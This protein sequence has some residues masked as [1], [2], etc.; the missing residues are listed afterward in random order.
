MDIYWIKDKKQC[1][2]ATVPDVISRLQIGELTEDSLGWHAGCQSW[3]PLR[4]LPALADFLHK[5][6]DSGT[7][8]E[9]TVPVTDAPPAETPNAPATSPTATATETAPLPAETAVPAP[10]MPALAPEIPGM[11]E[12]ASQRVYLPSPVARLLARFVDGGL[13][14]VLY[15]GVIAMRDLPYDA[16]LILMANPLLWLP[17]LFLEA[18]MLSTWGTTPGKALMGIR[19]TTF[20]EVPRLSYLRALM[21]AVMVFTLG[22]GLMVPQL[23]LIMLGFEYW[24]LRRRGITPWDARCSTLPTQKEPASPSRHTLAVISLYISCVLYF[25]CMRPWMPGMIDDIGKTNPELAQSL[26]ALMPPEDKKAAAPS[27][28]TP[29]T[30][31]GSPAAAGSATPAPATTSPQD[32]SLPGI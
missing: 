15:G 22:L 10:S 28:E 29:S 8:E 30:P 21:R 26:R 27:T 12:Y 23:L 17:L 4:E 2:P 6:A 5:P 25:S 32:L 16:A 11:Q 14:A 1:G 19:V 3:L 9:E 7:G 31:A 20:G 18:W 13:Y 24:M